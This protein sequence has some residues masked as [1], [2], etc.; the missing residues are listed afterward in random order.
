MSWLVDPFARMHLAAGRARIKRNR[1]A[2]GPPR[3][4]RIPER[5]SGGLCLVHRSTKRPGWWQATFIDEHGEPWLDT[6][7]PAFGP[8]VR[9]LTGYGLD[10]Q[11]AADA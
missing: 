3:P 10:W 2:A 9:R 5:G 1:I 4:V 7:G 8:L 6:E 11:A